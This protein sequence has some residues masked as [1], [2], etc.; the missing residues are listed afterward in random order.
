MD[1]LLPSDE[2]MEKMA[3][4]YARA[5]SG[6][7]G[8]VLALNAAD[9]ESSLRRRDDGGCPV[10]LL[11][12]FAFALGYNFGYG[13]ALAD[14]DGNLGRVQSRQRRDGNLDYFFP[15]K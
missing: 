1:V 6:T 10:F 2:T 12:Y 5:L 9:G 7:D 15:R 14:S 13:N 4:E 8:K 3:K 11:L